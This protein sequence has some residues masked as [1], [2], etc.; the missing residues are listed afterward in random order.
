MS[1]SGSLKSNYPILLN[2]IEIPYGRGWSEKS[3]VVENSKQSEAGTSIYSV[4]RFDKLSITA[5]FGCKYDLA[6]TLKGLSKEETIT[7]KRY[8]V[9]ADAYEERTVVMRNFQVDLI[10]GSETI[11]NQKGIWAVS[12]ALNEI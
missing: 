10:T 12:F 4:T 11:D 7:L 5:K 8:D 1:Y 2:N 3:N 6:K 9:L